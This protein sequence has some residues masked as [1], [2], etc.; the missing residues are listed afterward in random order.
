MVLRIR[1]LIMLLTSDTD[2]NWIE[3]HRPLNY[4][5]LS[6]KVVAVGQYITLLIGFLSDQ[7]DSSSINFQV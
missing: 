1:P 7:C 4:S 6:S 5:V 2:M 3:I